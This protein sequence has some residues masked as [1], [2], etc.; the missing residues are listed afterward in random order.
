[1]IVWLILLA[2]VIGGLITAFACGRLW[3]LLLPAP[4]GLAMAA[5][6]G[7]EFSG[8]VIHYVIAIA[9]VGYVGLALGVALRRRARNR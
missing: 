5:W 6:Y 4:A 2:L 7:W 3:P 9:F 8:I 1:M